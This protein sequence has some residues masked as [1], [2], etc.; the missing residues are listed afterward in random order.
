MTSAKT[1]P[2]GT[3]LT[4]RFPR[5]FWFANGAELC[6]RAA[7]YGM[8]ITLYR[9]LNTEV[10]FTDPETGVVVSI[11]AGGMYLLPTFMGILAD[12][13]GFRRALMLAFALLT[14][15]YALLGALQEKW[16][17]VVALGL[18]MTG[19]AIVKPVISG[20][21]AKCSS[22]H[23]R[24]RAMSIFYMMINI[25]SF[26]GKGLAGDLNERLG[27]Q[28]INFYAAGMTF[29][30][31]ILVTL[32]YRNV[33]TH[34]AGKTAAEALRGLGRVVCNVRFLALILIVAGFWLIQ[35]QLY[36]AM[37]TYIERV[38][39]KGYKPEWLANINPLTVVIFV[40]PITHLVRR[41]QPENAIGIG[42]LIIPFTALAIGLGPLLERWV[43]SSVDLGWFRA[44]PLILLIVVGI[45]L[46][47][48]AECFL[49]PKFLEYVSKQAPPSEIG[50]YLGFGHLHSFFAWLAAFIA[51][52]LLL[53]AFCPDPRKLDPSARHEWRLATD[54]KY[55]L[56]L[57]EAARAELADQVPV[58][59]SI[60][61]VLREHGHTVPEDA[62]VAEVE[63]KDAWRSDPERAWRIEQPIVTLEE[64][65]TSPP[66][67]FVRGV[68]DQLHVT[69]AALRWAQDPAVA[70]VVHACKGETLADE[71]RHDKPVG[72]LL[73][74]TLAGYGFDIP[75]RA[76]V[77]KEKPRDQHQ[78]EFRWKVVVPYYSMEE[79]KLET[80]ADARKAGR[81]RAL[82]DTLVLAATARPPQDRPAL[83]DAYD[84]AHYIWYVF[85]SVGALAFLS[86]LA[87]KFITR[88]LDR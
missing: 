34:G 52:G 9:Y 67:R 8:F 15:G 59:E 79:A 31:L 18:I 57:E 54:P 85:A 30:A 42:L 17:A 36:G 14:V 41:F 66:G 60:A 40:V 25:G 72:P 70:D 76:A 88:R 43:G 49:S 2:A 53:D 29:L 26:S 22:D 80:D 83:P 58:P 33:D 35:G 44:H 61:R 3:Q 55:V 48:L 6:E 64:N 12:K 75:E 86:L 50:L 68:P 71:L 74:A 20:T 47:G 39:G 27:L 78:R 63:G 10:G 21:A 28:Y 87:F 7:Y 46:Q 11:F 56:T 37:P 4:W 13:M 82:R 38:L 19:G 84:R 77:R 16:S 23:N 62:V 81:T 32:F 24:A 51:A 65:W 73:R 5:T 45:S 1:H 69:P